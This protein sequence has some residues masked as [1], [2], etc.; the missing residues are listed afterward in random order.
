MDARPKVIIGSSRSRNFPE[1]SFK[2]SPEE[3]RQGNFHEFRKNAWDTFRVIPFPTNIEESWRRSDLNSMPA[4]SFHLPRGMGEGGKIKIPAGY[5]KQLLKN[6]GGRV[7]LVPGNSDVLVGNAI[8]NQGVIFTDL[9]TA[10][11]EYPKILEGSMGRVVPAKDGKFAALAT[12]FSQNGML[13]YIPKGVNIKAPLSGFLW[14]DKTGSALI[15]HLVIWVDEGSSASFILESASPSIP[16]ATL[17]VSNI[18]ILVGKGASLQFVELQELGKNAWNFSH[19]RARIE[20]GGN[21]DWIVG[22]VGSRFTKSFLNMDLAG[23]GAKG[24]MSGFYFTNGNQHIDL[25]TEQDHHAPRTTS[26]LLFKGALTSESRVVWQGMIYVSPEAHKADGYQANRNLLLSKNSRADSIPGL[27]ILTDDVR[28]THGSTISRLEDEPM[29]YLQSRGIS[30][31]DAEQLLVQGFFNP[32]IDRIPYSYLQR[33][34]RQV[35]IKKWNEY[36]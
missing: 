30:Q 8:I 2:F 4:D 20:E 5:R 3:I 31:R 33:K 22:N 1:K 32:I 25:D 26:D 18:E 12:A 14:G 29:F 23:E 34:S 21:L 7:I 24:R 17:H 10:E 28:C 13:L 11:Q 16:G 19:A 36:E 27:E 9:R 35:I 15:S 6:S